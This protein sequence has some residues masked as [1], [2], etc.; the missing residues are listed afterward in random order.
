M[1]SAVVF[2]AWLERAMFTGAWRRSQKPR[3]HV[4]ARATAVESHI[5]FIGRSVVDM[6]DRTGHVANG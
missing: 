4:E 2:G 1:T 3:W 5:S 6:A